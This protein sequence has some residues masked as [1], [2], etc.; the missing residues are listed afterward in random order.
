MPDSKQQKKEGRKEGT[1]WIVNIL[2]RKVRGQ[3]GPLSAQDTS[4]GQ[5]RRLQTLAHPMLTSATINSCLVITVLF[6]EIN[7][8]IDI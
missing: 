2:T 3:A 8:I 4:R 1:K 7:I 6:D 5:H